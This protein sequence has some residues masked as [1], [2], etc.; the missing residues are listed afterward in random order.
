MSDNNPLVL[1]HL[2]Q[3]SS[4]IHDLKKSITDLQ[5]QVQ[6]VDERL[7]LVERCI[8]N[9]HGNNTQAPTRTVWTDEERDAFCNWLAV[10]SDAGDI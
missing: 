3:I 4:G 10:N 8:A 1:A 2:E 5:Q 7:L 6:L 9:L